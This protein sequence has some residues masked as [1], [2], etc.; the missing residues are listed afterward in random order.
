MDYDS[1]RK[2]PPYSPNMNLAEVSVTS[3]AI[4]PATFVNLSAWI[5]TVLTAL[6]LVALM[7]IVQRTAVTSRVNTMTDLIRLSTTSCVCV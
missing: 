2:I 3:F 5:R 4:Y 1:G 7:Q 6:H